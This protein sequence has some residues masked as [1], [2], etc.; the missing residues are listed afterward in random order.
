MVK[1]LKA[2]ALV[3]ALILSAFALFTVYVDYRYRRC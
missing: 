3:A 2:I 1:F